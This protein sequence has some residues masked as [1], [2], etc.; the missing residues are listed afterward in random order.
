MKIHTILAV[1]AIGI[2]ASCGKKSPQTSDPQDQEIIEIQISKPAI[3]SASNAGDFEV[4]GR[5]ESY[6][7]SQIS[8][9]VMGNVNQVYI[10]EGQKVRQGQLLMQ[11]KATDLM[12]QKAG[13][14]SNLSEAN[15]S[16]ELAQK[17]YHRFKKLHEQSSAT[18][19]ELDQAQQVYD[20]SRNRLEQTKQSLI[21]IQI[22]IREAQVLSPFDGTV[23][24]VFAEAGT[25]AHPGMPLLTIETSHNLILKANVPESEIQNIDKQKEV[26]IQLQ[27]NGEKCMGKI[28]QLNPSSQFSGSQ[29]EIEIKPDPKSI[30]NM[31]WKAG[32]FANAKIQRLQGKQSIQKDQNQLIIPKKALIEKGQL[33][34]VFT[35]S[36]DQRAI[37]RWVR[38]GKD[39]GDRIEIVSGLK[40]NESY[41]TEA[42][43]RL[44]NGAPVRIKQ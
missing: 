12:A 23:T 18:D 20:A 38:I 15:S 7:S 6:K 40:Q 39:F 30:I 44:Y 14:E 26:V 27:S 4:N 31:N 19:F 17:N 3:D 1:F 21:Q 33:Y 28:A 9:R 37:L 29:Y 34:G 24:A 2:V 11:I 42:D 25:L 35:V 13:L 41:I 36:D 43:S 32:M 16:F 8:S 5:L 10:R 22:M